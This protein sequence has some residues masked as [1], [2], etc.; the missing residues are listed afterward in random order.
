MSKRSKGAG[1]S[2]S[3]RYGNGLMEGN[4]SLVPRGPIT[5]TR[6]GRPI[7]TKIHLGTVLDQKGEKR[8]GVKWIKVCRGGK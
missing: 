8:C 3:I 5:L 6:H 4:P 2:M 1:C 7:K